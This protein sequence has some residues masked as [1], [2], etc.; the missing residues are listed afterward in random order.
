MS[1]SVMFGELKLNAVELKGKGQLSLGQTRTLKAGET[2][3]FQIGKMS[4]H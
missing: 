1:V 2:A 3:H 4:G